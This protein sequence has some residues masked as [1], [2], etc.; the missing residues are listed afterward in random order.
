MAYGD[1]AKGEMRLETVI[2]SE[3]EDFKKAQKV[4]EDEFR[5]LGFA[6]EVSNL[7]LKVTIKWAIEQT[8]QEAFAKTNMRGDGWAWD[9]YVDDPPVEVA[10]LYLTC[11]RKIRIRSTAHWSTTDAGEYGKFLTANIGDFVIAPVK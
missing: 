7:I 1:Y 6:P 4:G 2:D 11:N 9:F 8:A 5:C 3:S 10:A